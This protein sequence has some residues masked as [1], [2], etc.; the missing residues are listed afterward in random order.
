MKERFGSHLTISIGCEVV[1]LNP[2]EGVD[3]QLQ[4]A[5]IHPHQLLG[6]SC[7]RPQ[8]HEAM[9]QGWHLRRY[10]GNSS[11]LSDAGLDDV[12]NAPLKMKLS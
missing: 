3:L 1:F 4:L 9:T 2:S 7:H 6:G 12:K 10:A 8:Y 11:N 5:G